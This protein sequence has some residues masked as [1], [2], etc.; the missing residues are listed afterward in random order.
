MIRLPMSNEGHGNAV[1]QVLPARAVSPAASPAERIPSFTQVLVNDLASKDDP[2]ELQLFNNAA[3]VKIMFGDYL[4]HLSLDWRAMIFREIDR[5][6]DPAAWNDESAMIRRAS[7]RTFL[8]F[9][10][11][12]RPERRPSLGVGQD[13]SVLAAWLCGPQKIF[14]TYLPN[15]R[16]NATFVTRTDRDDEQ[17]TAWQGPVVALRERIMR[18]GVTACVGGLVE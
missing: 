10:D 9:I 5:L 14:V 1:I 17:I 11:H 18:E 4:R 15:D 8:R 7:F 16:V 2:L 6:L 13:G 12:S 3:D